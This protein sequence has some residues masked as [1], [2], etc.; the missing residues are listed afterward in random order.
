MAESYIIDGYV[1]QNRTDFDRAKKEKETIAYLSAHADMTDMK[2]VY[3]IYKTATQKHSFQTVFGLNYMEELR[4][5]LVESGI[6]T[7]DVLEPI[8]VGTVM[9]AGKSKVQTPPVADK[10]A[11]EYKQ[12]YEKAKSGSLIKN[13]LIVVLLAVIIGMVIITYKNQYSIF[14]YFTDYKEDMRGELL[15]EY[16]EWENTLKEREKEIEKKEQELGI[17][18]KEGKDSAK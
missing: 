13:L 9:A 16:E 7:E 8:P 6:V 14:T 10:E 18:P 17:S 12:A 3:K 2:A 1:F 5:C 4:K 11:I 15:D